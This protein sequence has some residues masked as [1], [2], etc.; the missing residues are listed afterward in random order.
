MFISWRKLL[1]S[2][3]DFLQ[4]HTLAVH[5]VMYTTLMMS[6]NNAI[7]KTLHVRREV[8]KLK[9]PLLVYTISK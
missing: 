5:H 7:N 8:E 2:C 4:P 1:E 6:V 9:T 3:P